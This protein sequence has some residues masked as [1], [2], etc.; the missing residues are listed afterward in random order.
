LL[1]G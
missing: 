1:K